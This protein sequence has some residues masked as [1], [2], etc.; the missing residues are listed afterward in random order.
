MNKTIC[1]SSIE[2]ILINYNLLFLSIVCT[3]FLFVMNRR[4]AA[5]WRRAAASVY[6]IRSICILP[7]PIC[8]FGL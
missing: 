6:Y 8:N 3:L 4:V 2:E 7:I 5:F 1:C